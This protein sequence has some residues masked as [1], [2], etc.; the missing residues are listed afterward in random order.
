MTNI[1]I[2]PPYK[3]SSKWTLSLKPQESKLVMY[4]AIEAGEFGI[5]G[6][7]YSA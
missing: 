1:K 6:Y 5:S 3:D 7:S 4:K 2:L